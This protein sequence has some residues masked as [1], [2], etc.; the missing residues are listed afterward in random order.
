MRKLEDVFSYESDTGN[1]TRNTGRKNVGTIT[2][3][4]YLRIRCNGKSYMAHRLAWFLFYG[5]WPNNFIDHINGDKL[6]NRIANLRDVETSVNNR[7]K[8]LYKK[9]SSGH[10]G[11]FWNK[12]NENWNSQ[13]S[14]S[15][16]N[17]FLGAFDS[18]A[19]AIKARKLAE[20]VYID[21]KVSFN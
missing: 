14:I 16:K 6:D 18:L 12:N 1:I 4:G 17:K 8:G 13:I 9:N 20:E 21:E 15:G 3:K 11:V 5:R 2:K 19:D 10:A 7:N